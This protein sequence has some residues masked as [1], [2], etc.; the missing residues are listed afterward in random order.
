M[1]SAL[2][3]PAATTASLTPA[4]ALAQLCQQD[5]NDSITRLFAQRPIM[6]LRAVSTVSGTVHVFGTANRPNLAYSKLQ[7]S[8]DDRKT[9]TD[10]GQRW[11]RATI[12]DFYGQIFGSANHDNF[13]YFQLE[14]SADQKNWTSLRRSTQPAIGDTLLLAWNSRTVPNGE[15]WLRLLVVDKTGNYNEPCAVHIVIRN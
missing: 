14:L 12:D 4:Q 13:S 9:W 5:P 6:D 8:G 15:Y 3:A 10:I 1:T 2:T 7:V 11:T